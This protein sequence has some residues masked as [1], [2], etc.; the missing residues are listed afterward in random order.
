MLCCRVCDER[1][2]IIKPSRNPTATNI[3]TYAESSTDEA[4]WAMLPASPRPSPSD[5]ISIG[6][7]TAVPYTANPSHAH[8]T[9]QRVVRR[10]FSPRNIAHHD[11]S[12]WGC[13]ISPISTSCPRKYR[14]AWSA[15]SPLPLDSSQ[16]GL[17]SNLIA[18][19]SITTA[20]SAM[21]RNIPFQR[22]AVVQWWSM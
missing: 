11:D 7:N 14:A 19:S 20:I 8:G 13:V 5:I 2:T 16:R 10:R 4:A 3:F 21:S 12:C 18:E 15:S 9:P 1:R 22:S 17:C 6:R